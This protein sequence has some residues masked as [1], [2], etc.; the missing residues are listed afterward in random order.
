MTQLRTLTVDVH[1]LTGD[2]EAETT[3]TVAFADHSTVAYAEVGGDRFIVD[4]TTQ[5]TA[6][7]ATDG[8]ASLQVFPATVFIPP[9]QYV[10]R[11]T[12]NNGAE[13]IQIPFWMPNSDYDLWNPDDI[14]PTPDPPTP[15]GTVDADEVRDIAGNLLAGLDQ[16]TYDAATDTLTWAGNPNLPGYEQEATELLHSRAGLLFWAAINEVPDTPGEQSA[17]GH[18]LT[19]HGT[20][21]GDYHWA[22]LLV[23]TA[24]LDDDSVTAQKLSAEVREAIA[25]A[26]VGGVAD[27]SLLP[28]KARSDTAARKAEWRRQFTSARNT[29]GNAFPQAAASNPGDVHIF[30]QDIADGLN[31]RD[32]ADSD[33]VITAAEA[34]DVAVLFDRLGW[35]RVGNI[36]RGRPDTEARTAAAE[37]ATAAESASEAAAAAQLEADTVIEVGPAFIHNERGSK[38]M[39]INIRHPLNAYPGA[40][41]MRVAVAGQPAVIVAYDH[42]LLHQDTLAEISQIALTNVWNQSDDIDDG[43]GGTRQVQKYPVGSYIPVAIQLAGPGAQPGEISTH[44]YRIVDVP[45][46]E[47]PDEIPAAPRVVEAFTAAAIAVNSNAEFT[48]ATARITP[49]SAATRIRAEGSFQA[50]SPEGNSP[51]DIGI[52]LRLYRGTTLLRQITHQFDHAPNNDHWTWPLAA[53]DIDAPAAT[54]EQ[55]Y[56]LRAI[57]HGKADNWSIT[58]RQLILTE[59]LA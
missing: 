37:A 33:T 12:P 50:R 4:P 55:T 10:A 53:T 57:R 58:Q 35:V 32:I 52:S 1:A 11:I 21:D 27:N 29:V 49:R 39:S 47:P 19:V 8:E 56:T 7:T 24:N 44:F 51:N 42:T 46:I 48:V 3:V 9:R 2:A 28:V 54:T 38:T 22:A 40:N 36:V 41:T 59:I 13:P 15:S 45:V 43:M 14:A 25:A 5:V 17:I 18:V 16:F 20:D 26:M 6:D 34:G 31:W 30:P 23:G